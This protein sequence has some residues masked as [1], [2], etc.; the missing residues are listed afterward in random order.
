[1]PLPQKMA[2]LPEQRLSL[3]W[4]FRNSALDALGPY[5]VSHYGR[6][7]N[8]RYILLITCMATRAI[9][10]FPLVS[11]SSQSFLNALTKFAS[12]YPGLRHIR[13][14]NGTN[15]RGANTLCSS[16]VDQFNSELV[17]GELAQRMIDIKFNCPVAPHTG[18]LF[19]RLVRSVKRCL[20]FVMG[21]N[22]VDFD[23]FDTCLFKCSQILNSRP[24][25][26]SSN[27][28][29]AMYCLSPQDFLMPYMVTQK[30]TFDPPLTYSSAQLRGSWCDARRLAGE[31]RERWTKEY[32]LTLQDRPKWVKIQKELYLGQLVLIS[33]PNLPRTHWRL[34]RVES[35]LPSLD[36]ITRRYKIKLPDGRFLERHHNVLIPL[37]LEYETGKG[38]NDQ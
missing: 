21:Q 19:E 12:I 22:K 1:M 27:D 36:L 25:N 15:F 8:K 26:S 11:M 7:M 24:L 31:F 37:E 38:D 13:C 18:G 34:G 14:D 5:E 16:L 9:A 10:L 29:N 17:V 33:E 20:H 6:G 23:A 3:I 32:L 35:K 30:S 4:P 2:V 28:I